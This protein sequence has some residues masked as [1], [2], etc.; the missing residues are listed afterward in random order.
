MKCP[1]C[2]NDISETEIQAHMGKMLGESNK[3]KTSGK[4]KLASR[5]NG[6][7]GGRPKKIKKE[8]SSK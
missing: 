5:L 4:R 6:K 1:H 7:L 2:K 3:G 8:D